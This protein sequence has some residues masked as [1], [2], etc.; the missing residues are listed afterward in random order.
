MKILRTSTFILLLIAILLCNLNFWVNAG[1]SDKE[2][3]EE[4]GHMRVRVSV[5]NLEESQPCK[6]AASW[7]WGAENR[8]PKTLISAF[9]VKADDK[10]IFVP[11]SAFAD[12]GNPRTVRIE[13]GKDKGNFAVVI[14]GGDAATSYSA[15]L[16]FKNNFLA[17]R[18]VKHGE[19]PEE[20]WEETIY[21][22]KGGE[23]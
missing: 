1:Q 23:N 16:E 4:F 11:I 6:A 15:R 13:P 10:S 3:F 7:R 2:L 21:K 14:V 17:K 19:F 9:E 20:S 22:F 5:V 8:C 18:L 12:L